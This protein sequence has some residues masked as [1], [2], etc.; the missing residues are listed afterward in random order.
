[1][2]DLCGKERKRGTKQSG[3][4]SNGFLSKVDLMSKFVHN[5]NHDF[6]AKID[7]ETCLPWKDVLGA[8]YAAL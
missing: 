6:G 8:S 2:I 4:D 7:Q 5:I 1:M 3:S